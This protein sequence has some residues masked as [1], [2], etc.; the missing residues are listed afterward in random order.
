MKCLALFFMTI[1]V[2]SQVAFAGAPELTGLNADIDNMPFK[3]CVGTGS[4]LMSRYAGQTVLVEFNKNSIQIV[5]PDGKK[6]TY[7]SAQSFC[8]Q[9]VQKFN[10]QCTSQV[11]AVTNGSYGGGD[12]YS[13]SK[14]CMVPRP[15]IPNR[16]YLY[17]LDL[18]LTLNI[19]NRGDG[20][21]SATGW[22]R[23]VANENG[24]NGLNLRDCK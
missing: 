17:R 22:L 23:C 18:T 4:N 16:Y 11:D 3:T 9:D 8:D 7:F 21:K 15:G 10:V 19:H 13:Y 6:M 2:L 24:F 12:S 20:I 14:T 5:K 1:I